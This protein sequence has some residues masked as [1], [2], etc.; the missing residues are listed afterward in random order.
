MI[1]KAGKRWLNAPLRNHR[2]WLAFFCIGTGLQAGFV[3]AHVVAHRSIWHVAVT[4]L[5]LIACAVGAG[6]AF[7]NNEWAKETKA[8]IEQINDIMGRIAQTQI[9]KPGGLKGE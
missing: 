2:R 7:V 5:G 6:M 8:A 1:V 9:R 3:V 4:L